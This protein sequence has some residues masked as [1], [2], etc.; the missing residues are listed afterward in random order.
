MRAGAI[1]MGAALYMRPMVRVGDAHGGVWTLSPEDLV[2]QENDLEGEACA[3]AEGERRGQ[4]D[5]H[6]LLS[7][8]VAEKVGRD[9]AADM[10]RH[11]QKRLW[12]WHTEPSVDFGDLRTRWSR[13][14][15][16]RVT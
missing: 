8:G 3:G 6:S 11:D 10:D 15:E 16:T 5:H 12:H 7:A 4:V 9:A 1:P 14:E 13:P 2:A